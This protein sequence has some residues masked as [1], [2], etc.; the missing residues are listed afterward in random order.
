MKNAQVIPPGQTTTQMLIRGCALLAPGEP[1]RLLH[2]QDILISGNR[3]EAVGPGGTMIPDLTREVNI[4]KGDHC[5]ALPG[6]INAHT[7]SLENVLKATSSSLPLELWLVPL[8]SDTV[9]WTPRFVYLS[10]IIG[11][12]EMLKTGTTAALDH[13]W[14]AAGVAQ[15]YLDAS[16]QAY[17][18]VGIRATVAPSIEDQDLVLEE[19]TRQGLIFPRH[20]FVDRFESWPSIDEQLTTLERFIARWHNAEDGRLR[21][22]VG[23]S[24]IHWCSPYLLQSC[25]DLANHFAT[26]IHLHAVE[27]QLQAAVIRE[28]L[29]QGGIAYLQQAGM[30]RP[31]TSLAHAIWLER[32]DLDILAETQTTVVHNPVSNLRLGSGRFPL[33]EA[34]R[35]GINVALGSDG[36]ASNDT[37][38]MFGV[39][40]MTGLMHNLPEDDYRRWPQ[41]TEILNLATTGGAS[42][43]GL[44][45][46]LGQISPGYLADIVLLDLESTAFLPLRDPYLHLVYCEHGTSVR[47]V[48]V[49]GDIVVE[50]GVVCRVD[51]EA[52]YQE[53]RE[54]CIENRSIFS[55]YLPESAVTHEL[56]MKLDTLRRSILQQTNNAQKMREKELI[57]R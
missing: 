24:G 10:T 47:T 45:E 32:G 19:G 4:V 28:V 36:S 35:H 34:L 41:P 52:L 12:I 18:D 50:R 7:H 3:I 13:L 51:E 38:N 42:A 8:F 20:P 53:L 6:L 23:P 26:G 16:M 25:L 21:C 44:H 14:T 30:L 1:G 5:I 54:L 22:I 55:R 17:K 37:Q 31:G 57:Y 56:L 43:L 46:E 39:L 40:K 49:H 11:A 15:E 9:T 29:G 48:I 2:D 27:T 33:N